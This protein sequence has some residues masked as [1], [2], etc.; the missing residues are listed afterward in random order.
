MNTPIP[1]PVRA[2]KV[3]KTGEYDWTADVTFGTDEP[4]SDDPTITVASSSALG[5]PPR[6]GDVMMVRPPEIL[7][8][9]NG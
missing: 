7:F 5:R 8:F 2:V 3:T 9:A 6:A 1:L 4:C